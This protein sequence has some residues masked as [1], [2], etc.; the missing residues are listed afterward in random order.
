MFQLSRFRTRFLPKHGKDEEDPPRL[1][2]GWRGWTKEKRRMRWIMRSWWRLWD[3]KGCKQR[4]KRRTDCGGWVSVC[5]L[6]V[7]WQEPWQATTIDTPLCVHCEPTSLSLS[8]LLSASFP[9]WVS[10]LFST[11]F[12]LK[13]RLRTIEKTRDLVIDN[14]VYPWGSIDEIRESRSRAWSGD[15]GNRQTVVLV[16]FALLFL[17]NVSIRAILCFSAN[18]FLAETCSLC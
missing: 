4:I 5:S 9:L 15:Q 13:M 12:R 18:F 14:C 11:F 16:T 6:S 8:L 7:S 3:G 2:R 10:S 1:G 17:S